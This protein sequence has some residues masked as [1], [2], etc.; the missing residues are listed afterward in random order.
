MR[1]LEFR[2]A[3]R[4]AVLVHRRIGWGRVGR[5]IVRS[6]A[7]IF[8][9]AVK[10]AEPAS[11]H[12][13]EQLDRPL[14]RLLRRQVRGVLTACGG[15]KDLQ[16]RRPNSAHAHTL[17]LA[18]QSRR[19]KLKHASSPPRHRRGN[20]QR[21]VPAPTTTLKRATPTRSS[22]KLIPEASPHSLNLTLASTLTTNP[23]GTRATT[24]VCALLH[25]HPNHPFDHRRVRDHRA[26]DEL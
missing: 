25:V 6:F 15:K 5:K 21:S 26:E 1:G 16:T 8:A 14:P 23:P 4:V 13:R 2:A 20:Q 19:P 18:T 3:L 10:P 7:H 24:R 9:C 12:R 22:A 11:L 17:A